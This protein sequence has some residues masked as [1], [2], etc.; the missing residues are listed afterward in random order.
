MN[1]VLESQLMQSSSRRRE[2]WSLIGR[3]WNSIEDSDPAAEVAPEQLAEA[4][5]RMEKSLVAIRRSAYSRSRRSL[6]IFDPAFA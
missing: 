4:R 6:L 3:L 2:A 1:D 5:R